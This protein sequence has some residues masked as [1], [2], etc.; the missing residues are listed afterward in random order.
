MSV[1]PAPATVRTPQPVGAPATGNPWRDLLSTMDR[2]VASDG[3]EWCAGQ[4][5]VSL[6]KFLLEESHELAEEIETHNAAGVREELGDVLLQVVFHAR[7]ATNSATNPFTADDVVR[8][9]IA[10]MVRRHPHVFADQ[11]VAGDLYTQ[12]DAIKRA[13]KQRD[14][15]LD[16]IP[17]SLGALAQAQ[18]VLGRAQ[19][20]G[21]V[22]DDAADAV[23][24][25]SG[26]SGGHASSS[27]FG[28]ELFDL[29]QRAQ[30]AGVDAEGALRAATRE[31]S[32]Q[33]RAKEEIEGAPTPL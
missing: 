10:K 7:L 20:A 25:G 17:G 15:V 1:D 23:P 16:G 4:T 30:A 24:S 22:P 3:C 21:L 28:A 19:R 13:E 8:D 11:E 9:L 2:L 6:V 29:V 18:K 32:G 33:V 5:H 27:D 14:S 12:W 31:F 26:A